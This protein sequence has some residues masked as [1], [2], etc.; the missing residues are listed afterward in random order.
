[1]K[2]AGVQSGHLTRINQ[3]STNSVLRLRNFSIKTLSH[4]GGNNPVLGLRRENEV[5]WVGA[6]T[7]TRES[8]ALSSIRSVAKFARVLFNTS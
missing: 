1:M 2:S 5:G 4:R 6:K 7:V 8:S 3:S